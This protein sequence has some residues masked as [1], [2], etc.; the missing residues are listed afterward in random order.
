MVEPD[1]ERTA[2]RT[3]VPAYQAELWEEDAEEM[4]MSKSEFVRTMVQA[5]R[6]GFSG[7]DPRGEAS[8]DG[9]ADG[10]D[11]PGMTERVV[12]EL[13]GGEAL[14]WDEL[15]SAL[16]DDVEARL[17]DALDELQSEDRVRYSGREGGYTLVDDGR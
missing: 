3:Y 12:E 9:S 8:E 1:T 6:R 17:E 5:G 15:L 11:G 4:D 10:P 7:R 16:T 13:A 14:A 2:V